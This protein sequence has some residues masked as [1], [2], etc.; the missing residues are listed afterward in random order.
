MRTKLP[1]L[2]A[3]SGINYVRLV[4]QLF[5][6]LWRW[7]FQNKPKHRCQTKALILPK[8]VWLLFVHKQSSS[9]PLP[10]KFGTWRLERNKTWII[11]FIH[12]L[13]QYPF[14]WQKSCET[15]LCQKFYHL[16]SPEEHR[17]QTSSSQNKY[18]NRFISNGIHLKGRLVQKNRDCIGL[19]HVRHYGWG[20]HIINLNPKKHALQKRSKHRNMTL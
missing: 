5:S 10:L 20:W 6:C 12:T 1:N 3:N 13:R 8:L 4:T 7:P 2:T 15:F 11:I 16:K 17:A 9:F 19:S 18:L 14:K